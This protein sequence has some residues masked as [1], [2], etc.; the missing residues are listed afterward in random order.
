M[1]KIFGI[2]ECKTGTSSLGKAFE[3]IGF[4]KHKG[5]DNKLWIKYKE[6]NIESILEV[7]NK[8]DCFEDAPWC[9]GDLYKILYKRFPKSKFILTI[10]DAESWFKSLRNF[11]IKGLGYS[12]KAI[13]DFDNKKNEIIEKYKRRNKKIKDFFKDKSEDLLIMNICQGDGWEKLCNFLNKSIPKEPFPHIG[14][15]D[16]K[17]QLYLG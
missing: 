3:L 7:A 4:K 14:R 1:N 6:N 5:W 12:Q 15:W 9:T 2:G 16:T 11:N 8:F 17:N 10:R 13:K